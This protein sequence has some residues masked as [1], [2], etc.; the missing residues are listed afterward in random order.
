MNNTT[1]STLNIVA[2]HLNIWFGSFLLIIGNIGCLINIIVFRSKSFHKSSFSIYFLATTCADLFLLNFVLFTR[3]LQNGFMLPIFETYEYICKFRAYISSL[4]SSLSF[5]FFLMVSIDRF[6]STH[7]KAFYR[8]WGNQYFLALKLIP[9]L[10]LF[11]MIILSHR[12]MLYGLNPI[13]GQ[14][15]PKTDI[16]W[17]YNS[18]YKFVFTGLIPPLI[19]LFISIL[20]IRNIRL[21]VDRGNKPLH[22]RVSSIEENQNKRRCSRLQKLDNQLTSILL[23]QL[24]VSFISFLP[25]SSELLYTTLSKNINKSNDYIAWE[26]VFIQFIHL[27]SYIFYS[28]NCYVFLA[29]SQSFRKQIIRIYNLKKTQRRSQTCLIT[30]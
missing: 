20:I 1:N 24:C 18:Y 14:C 7:L 10:T 26:N 2:Q 17:W 19:I 30:N 27:S 8:S 9:C 11:W 29:S 3:I 22:R 12:F 15:E 16:Y 13:S 23:I 5:T 6:F 25:Y 28:T 21:V 4:T